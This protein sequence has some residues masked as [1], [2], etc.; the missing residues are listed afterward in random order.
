MERVLL[1]VILAA[2]LVAAFVMIRRSLSPKAK[3][4]ACSGCPMAN[5]C[6]GHDAGGHDVRGHASGDGTEETS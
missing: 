3:G 6:G 4:G 1:T 5:E 2:A